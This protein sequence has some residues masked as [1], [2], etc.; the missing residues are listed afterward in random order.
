[1]LIQ[2]H[3]RREDCLLLVG[4]TVVFISIIF[5]H[6]LSSSFL[7]FSLRCSNMSRK[8]SLSIL[9]LFLSRFPPEVLTT[10]LLALSLGGGC[11]RSQQLLV[12]GDR[13]WE[14]VWQVQVRLTDLG[15]TIT[16]SIVFHRLPCSM[17]LIMLHQLP[18]PLGLACGILGNDGKW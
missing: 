13:D 18:F 8:S 9:P 6:L 16:S 12:P 4:W 14:L 3:Q 2:I 5:F 17:Q 7:I 1:M 15:C 10:S 11:Q